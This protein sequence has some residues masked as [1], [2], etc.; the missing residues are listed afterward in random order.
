MNLVARIARL[1]SRPGLKP[2]RV[3]PPYPPETILD[4][5][6]DIDAAERLLAWRRAH[7][8][9]ALPPEPA[10]DLAQLQRKR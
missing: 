3:V 9:E 7:P 4:T 2:G 1:E 6:D 8:G 10:A 5:P